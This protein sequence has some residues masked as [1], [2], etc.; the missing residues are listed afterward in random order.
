MPCGVSYHPS[1]VRVGEP[2]TSRRAGDKGLT[3]PNVRWMGTFVCEHCTVR[4]ILRRELY[5][6]DDIELMAYERMRMLDVAHNW[7]SNTHANYQSRISLVQ[8]FEDQHQL[9]ILPTPSLACPSTDPSIPLMWCQEA[10]SLQ[11]GVRR[12]G[13][14]HTV[15]F[16]A[17]RSLRS[18]V[19]QAY[20]WEAAVNPSGTAF[21]D[22]SKR[23]LHAPC[24]PTD[25]LTHQLHATGMAARLG[26]IPQ[27][28]K[29]LLDRH[30]RTLDHSL[31]ELYLRAPTREAAREAVLAGSLNLLLWLGWLR[32]SEALGLRW[33]DFD[34]VLPTEGPRLDLPLGIGAVILRLAPETKS[35]RNR[36]GDVV[37]AYTTTSGLS[38][39][40]WLLRATALL[41]L[42]RERLPPRP[43][44][45]TMTGRLWSSLYFREAH[46]YPH[47]RRLQD[48]GDA[49]L[50]NVD[51]IL[52]AYWSL[53]SYRRG[54]RTHV[55][56][57]PSGPYRRATTVETY[58]HARWRQRRG[59][60]EDIDKVY[61]EWS[62]FNRIQLTL[63]CH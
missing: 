61:Q 19:S 6:Q 15:S 7:S 62:I 56:N 22:Q 44:F 28:S 60:T 55:S 47:L 53:H 9:H 23:L 42:D 29:P 45:T 17:V 38:L 16:S 26:V 25:Q 1:C 36:E 48:A 59:N 18:A 46:L 58:E 5:R 34:I 43:L 4:A 52:T 57:P 3:F 35:S 10:Y 49:Y 20:A 13:S 24:R 31:N 40:K 14:D 33:C 37:V 8:R 30:V 54:A 63:W 41:G 27:P 11:P 12:R 32:A 50:S 2:F 51:S 21:L 39:G